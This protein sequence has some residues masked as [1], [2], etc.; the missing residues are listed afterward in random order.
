MSPDGR[1]ILYWS[2]ARGGGDSPTTTNRLMRFPVSGGSPEQ[3]LES[4]IDATTDFHCPSRPAG[5]CVL[6]R[7]QQG[8]LIFYALDPVQGQGKEITRTKLGP[9]TD[10]VWAVSP[11]GLRIAVATRDQLPEK[12]RILDLRNGT[13][14]DLQLPHG[15]RIFQLGW[16]A[17]G[18]ALFAA[19]R[20]TGYFI[21]RIELNGTT[22][23][24]LDRGRAQ[25]LGFLARH[26]TV[27]T[28]HLASRPRRLTPGSLR[29]SEPTQQASEDNTAIKKS[30]RKE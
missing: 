26:P 30:W 12:V 2:S 20:S 21:A 6:S 16:A 8:Q 22:R 9:A 18:N 1:W 24:L 28:W 29:I 4:R 13:E 23:V 15:W 7:S 10:L 25:W 5:S 27:A 19:A 14:R 17:D 11:E 3:V